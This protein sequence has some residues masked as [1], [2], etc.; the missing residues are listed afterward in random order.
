MTLRDEILEFAVEVRREI[1]ISVNFSLV[2]T[3][4]TSVERLLINEM[5]LT[6]FAEIDVTV[7]KEML[8]DT[9]VKRLCSWELEL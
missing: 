7:N 4:S 5:S 8:V 9:S 2:T 6:Q 3:L 1:P